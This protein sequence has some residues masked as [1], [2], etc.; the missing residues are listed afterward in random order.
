MVYQIKRCKQCNHHVHIHK[1]GSR[2]IIKNVCEHLQDKQ[3]VH[4]TEKELR[5][6]VH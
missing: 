6:Y 5:N 4:M 2:F 1:K 3:E